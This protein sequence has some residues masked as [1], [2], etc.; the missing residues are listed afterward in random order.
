MQDTLTYPPNGIGAE[1]EPTR[2]V[3][4][5]DGIDEAQIALHDQVLER[6]TLMDKG[7]GHGNNK[8]QITF[9]K[10]LLGILIASLRQTGQLFFLSQGEKWITRDVLHVCTQE[11]SALGNTVCDFEFFHI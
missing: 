8:T 6:N 3:K 11:R 5:L 2:R 7:F 9:D 4:P 10:A 1:F